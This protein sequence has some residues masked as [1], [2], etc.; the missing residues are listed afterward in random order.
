MRLSWF[1]RGQ[2]RASG[3]AHPPRRG[4]G[5]DQDR[6]TIISL[7]PPASPRRLTSAK[8]TALRV[9]ALQGDPLRDVRDATREWV[10]RSL[11]IGK[12]LDEWAELAGCT[13][14]R[15][16]ERALHR[17]RRWYQQRLTSYHATRIT[18]Q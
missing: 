5:G 10:F 18:Q 11:L 12:H 13:E 9:R 14:P 4:A 3:D 6:E 16:L 17:V 1:A 2:H 15:E 8:V 7:T